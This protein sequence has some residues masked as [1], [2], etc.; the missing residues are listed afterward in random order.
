MRCLAEKSC[1]EM[2]FSGASFR[3][4]QGLHPAARFQ[5][6][7]TVSS[8]M[9]TGFSRTTLRGL[10]CRLTRTDRLWNAQQLQPERGGNLT[11]VS[12]F[13]QRSVRIGLS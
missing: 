3:S 6:F 7:S 5:S 9:L 4:F 10:L 13:H 8:S 12:Q 2:V 1:N 11:S